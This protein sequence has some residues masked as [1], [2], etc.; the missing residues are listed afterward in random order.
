MVSNVNYLRTYW[1]RS[2]K[3]PIITLFGFRSQMMSTPCRGTCWVG[4]E[5]THWFWC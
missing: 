2:Q 3:W 1:E 5:F 4:R